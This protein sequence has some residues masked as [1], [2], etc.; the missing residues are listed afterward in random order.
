[1]SSAPA[2]PASAPTPEVISVL[3]N[4]VARNP[5]DLDAALMLGS[6][7]YQ[8]GDPTGSAAVLKN[9]LSRHP[10]HHQT[11]LLL[12]RA[13]AR[14]GNPVAALATLARARQVK[15]DDVTAWQVAAALASE[16]RDWA[17]LLRIGRGWTE[18]HP[19]SAAAWQALS[20]AY[21]E[22]S[23]FAE[24]LASFDQ[25]LALQADQPEHL[26]SAARMAIAAQQ[27]ERAWQHLERALQLTPE[28][29]ELQFALCRWYHLTGDLQTATEYC[30]RV[31]AARPDYAPALIELG[32]LRQGRLSRAEIETVECLFQDRRTHPENRAMLGFTLGDAWDA[33][34]EPS[35]AFSA[36][37][38]A[39]DINCRLSDQEG[40]V[41]RAQEFE[42]ELALLDSLFADPVP[43][44]DPPASAVRP[45][46]VV[47]MP[48]S[49]TTLVESIL[50][51]HSRVFGGGELP[52][53]YDIYEELLAVARS[54]GVAAARSRLVADAENWR[55]RYLAALPE[56]GNSAYV[57]DKQPLNF[58]GIALLRML[59][60]H[61]PVFWMRRHPVDVGLSIY[62]HKFAKRW[63]CA[64]RLADIGHYYGV[65]ERM[66]SYWLDRFGASIQ[67]VDYAELVRNA[68]PAIRKLLAAADLEFEPACLQPHQTRRRVATF[69][70]V[71]V[72]KPM[73]TDF[74][75]RSAPYQQYLQPLLEALNKAGVATG[76]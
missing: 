36:W 60:P 42:A 31:L 57:V 33:L 22:D 54:Q 75:N 39:N 12:A 47:G 34:G 10:H 59:F 67:V 43:L 70:S 5:G 58:R 1:M 44:P 3:R 13:E 76:N 56:H 35:R 38:Q 71:Q 9:T 6:A 65:H 14:S 55:Q 18:A 66:F 30:D 48:R 19:Q 37:Q 21:F 72:Q 53:L 17:E 28:S 50:A 15:P 4:K 40:Y 23:R 51:A 61:A 69:S 16:L 26:T 25:V 46:F 63:P 45:I 68:E 27:Y 74:I 62:R 32:I 52:A 29:V 8:A 20:R 49:G 2:K 7:L 64:H 24:A 11:L 41:Y 73:T